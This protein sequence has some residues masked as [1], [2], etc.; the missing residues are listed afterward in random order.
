[1]SANIQELIDRIKT[2]GVEA[3]RKKAQEIER[4]AESQAKDIVQNARREAEALLSGARL[5]ARRAEESSRTALGH[6]ARDTIISL[7]RN[8]ENIL[9]NVTAVEIKETLTPDRLSH[10]IEKVIIETLK[11][12]GEAPALD[13]VLSHEDLQ[14]LKDGLMNRLHGS[15]K[16]SLHLRSS[17][18]LRGGFMI[19]FNQERCSFDFSDTALAEYLSSYVNASVGKILKESVAVREAKNV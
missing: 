18:N 10:I 2:D 14:L 6:A 5:E 17:D 7:H 15:L 4:D 16:S 11:H 13:V 1:M 19:G 12:S 8:I 9:K 3:A